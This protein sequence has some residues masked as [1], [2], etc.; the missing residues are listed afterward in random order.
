[1]KKIAVYCSS[2]ETLD[3]FYYEQAEKLG[4]WIGENGHTLVYGGCSLGLMEAVSNGV[5]ATGKGHITGVV[6]KILIEREKVSQNPDNII[7]CDDLTERKRIMMEESD[8]FIAMPGSIGTLDEAFSVMAQ[9]IIGIDKKMIIFWNLKGFWNGLFDF[10]ETLK[11]TGVVN[12]SIEALYLKA[13]TL[14][15]IEELCEK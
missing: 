5:K 9:H 6:P 4:K 3:K 1:M 8:I 11:P 12:K 7:Y 15:E 13:D 2:S 10:F 14:E